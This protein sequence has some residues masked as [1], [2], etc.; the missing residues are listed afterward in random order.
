MSVIITP[1]SELGK[2]LRRW[3]QH[4]TKL[5][6]D[7]DGVFKP[8]NPYVFRPYPKMVYK[9]VKKENGKVVCMVP[10]P[11]PVHFALQNA[12]LAAVAD[13]EALN[14][15]CHKIVESEQQWMVAKGQGWCESPEA[16]IEQFER[17]E[18]ALGNAAAEAAFAASRMSDKAQR[19][20]NQVQ[21]MTA[22]HVPD[23]TKRTRRDLREK[24]E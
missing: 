8:G 17:E 7:N 6:L 1:D 2:E 19:D 13:A 24:Q 10:L 20:F 15:R 5:A 12:Y 16:A 11:E 22:E 4:N 23:V 21:E 14:A 3:E 9:A 18:Q